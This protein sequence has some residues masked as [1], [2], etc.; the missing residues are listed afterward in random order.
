MKI[1]YTMQLIIHKIFEENKNKSYI[2]SIV[3]YMKIWQVTDFSSKFLYLKALTFFAK[4]I[5]RRDLDV[6]EKYFRRVTAPDAHLVLGWSAGDTAEAPFNDEG[7]HFVFHHARI[8]ILRGHLRE[9][10]HYIGDTAVW[11]PNLAAI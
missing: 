7:G 11:Y 5:F 4:D 3:P 6:L 2:C 8:R 10:G 9:H 1:K